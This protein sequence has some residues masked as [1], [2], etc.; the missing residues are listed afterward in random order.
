MV[1]VVGGHEI[2]HWD[3]NY[4]YFWKEHDPEP[5]EDPD[6]KGVGLD[7][8]GRYNSKITFVDTDSERPEFS[9]IYQLEP[10]LESWI[11]LAG[12]LDFNEYNYRDM[13]FSEC[14]AFGQNLYITNR[15]ND[16]SIMTVEPDGIHTPFASGF[17]GIESISVSDDGKDMFVSDQNGV[18]RIRKL[19]DP[20]PGPELVIREP[21]VEGD[22]V[23]TG[24][25][26]VDD[27]RLLWNE[28]ILFSNTDMTIEDEAGQA[29]PFSVTGS[30]SQFMIIVFGE[31]LLNDKYTITIADTVKSV[32]TGAAID[33]DNNG[34]AGGDAVLVME[35]RK[36]SDIDDNN[37]VNMLDFKR[38]AEDWLWEE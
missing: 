13:C 8:T 30:N 25:K 29:V 37:R 1:I 33:G 36:R 19:T 17:S 24:E 31:T 28:A 32:E 27:L 21:W 4:D 15:A 11:I 20:P 7:R 5:R 3:E 23:H 38:F 14:G 10:D 35:H 34:L 12:P 2:H 16:E 26:G 18:Y 22:D 9:Y 6:W